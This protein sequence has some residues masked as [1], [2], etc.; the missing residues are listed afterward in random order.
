MT[1]RRLALY[2]GTGVLVYVAA[3]A[4]TLPAPWVAHMVE[5]ASERKVVLRDPAGTAWEGS[6]RLYARQRAGA[7]VDLGPVRWN[8]SPGALLAGKL[9][10]ELFLGESAKRMHVEASPASMTLRGLDV[11]LP[12]FLV[13]GFAA[14]LA[15]LGPEG[16]VRIRSDSLRVDGD[17]VLGLAEVEWRS[18]RLAR[19]HGLDLGSHVA[20]L[21]GGGSK[22]DIELGTLEGPLQLSG[23]GTWTR[24]SGLVLAGSAEPRAPAVVPFLKTVC[25]EYRD[26]RCFFRY[27]GL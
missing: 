12:G 8:A 24:G 9:G 5:M 2:L 20:R 25:A 21:R 18:I 7:L 10:A 11:E 22:V 27:P 1:A 19:A 3:L 26:A 6:G 23:G 17:S 16:V 4:A 14:E 13:A 15:A